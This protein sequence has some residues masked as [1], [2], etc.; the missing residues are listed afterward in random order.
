MAAWVHE[1]CGDHRTAKRLIERIR[2][3]WP[4]YTRAQFSAALVHRSPYYPADKRRAIEDAFD[5][6]GF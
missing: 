4:D 5:R 1:L 6:L 3:S 2:R